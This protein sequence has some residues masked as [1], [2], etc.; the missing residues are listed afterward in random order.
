[1]PE[2]KFDFFV[3]KNTVK[4][5]FVLINFKQVL[6]GEAGLDVGRGELAAN[7]LQ[8]DLLNALVQGQ[9]V[10]EHVAAIFAHHSSVVDDIRILQEMP[11]FLWRDLYSLLNS[12]KAHRLADF[13]GLILR[14]YLE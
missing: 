7:D 11:Q 2:G 4:L 1:M 12:L 5:V 9:L 13:P 14:Q 8:E 3:P 10:E 6:D